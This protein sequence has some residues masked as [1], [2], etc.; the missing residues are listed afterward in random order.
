MPRA[1]KA[2]PDLVTVERDGAWWVATMPCVPG[3]VS[4]G[5]TRA[6]A[7]RNLAAAVRAMFDTYAEM[8]K[9]GTGVALS[10]GTVVSAAE[11]ATKRAKRSTH[12]A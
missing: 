11:S 5:R 2:D 4:Q 6:S 10:A 1:K 9:R 3:A 7:L 12:A 8:A